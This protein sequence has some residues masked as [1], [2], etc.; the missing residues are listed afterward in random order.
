M[1]FHPRPSWVLPVGG[2]ALTWV[3]LFQLNS[4]WFERFN[5]SPYAAWIFLP[6][7]VRVL[8][9]LLFQG[10]GVW[11]LFLGAMITNAGLLSQH[12]FEALALSTMS[13]VAPAVAVLLG[14]RWFKLRPA[15]EGMNG[16]QLLGLSA[17]AAGCSSLLH[18][19]L[20]YLLEYKLNWV[21]AVTSMTVGDF[22]GTLIV[23]YTAYFVM[24]WARVGR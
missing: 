2:V 8:A 17:L 21:Q 16:A 9:V 13:A 19:A 22:V 7:A 6:A 15:L 14:I 23:L 1:V 18:T 12:L 24:R 20:F 4:Y 11:G 3:V 5:V 10:R